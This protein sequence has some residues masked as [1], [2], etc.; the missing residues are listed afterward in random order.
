MQWLLLTRVE[1]VW[2]YQPANPPYSPP[3]PTYIGASLPSLDMDFKRHIFFVFF[4]LSDLMWE[5]QKILIFIFYKCHL[6]FSNYSIVRLLFV[7]CTPVIFGNKCSIMHTHIYIHIYTVK[8][9]YKGHSR[10]PKNVPFM[11]SCALYTG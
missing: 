8:P 9:V 10:E 6:Y 4:V 7:S 5:V 3:H 1:G 11:S 2:L